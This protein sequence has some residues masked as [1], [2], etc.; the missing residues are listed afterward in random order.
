MKAA[1]TITATRPRTPIRAACQPELLI[2]CCAIGEARVSPSEP[3]ADT[4]PMAMLRLS[5]E[6]ALAVT[7]MAMLDAV[8]DKA[9][10]THRPMPSVTL[11]AEVAVSAKA[12][13]RP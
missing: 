11:Q 9:R 2:K 12:R 13:P 3:N 4:E 7:L 1:G 8:Q 6:T 5:G 10:P